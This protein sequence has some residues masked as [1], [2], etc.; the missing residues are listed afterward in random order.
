MAI[1]DLLSETE[2]KILE[3]NARDVVRARKLLKKSSYTLD[4][5]K[6][7][8][9]IVKKMVNEALTSENVDFKKRI[10]VF[11]SKMRK[12]FDTK[13]VYT[14]VAPDFLILS[15]DISSALSEPEEDFPPLLDY[16]SGEESE[17]EQSADVEQAPEI[18]P[19]PDMS[20][21]GEAMIAESNRGRSSATTS[22]ASSQ[23][24]RATSVRTPSPIPMAS[25]R[26]ERSRTPRAQASSRRERTRS[27]RTPQTS[28]RRERSRSPREPRGEKSKKASKR[29]PSPV[30]VVEC[31]TLVVSDEDKPRI[32]HKSRAYTIKSEDPKSSS[33]IK[34]EEADDTRI[35]STSRSSIKSEEGG[36]ADTRVASRK[37]S[38]NKRDCPWTQLTFTL[39]K[40]IEGENTLKLLSIKAYFFSSRGTHDASGF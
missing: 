7:F 22:S 29:S 19:S 28:E 32:V 20:A 36:A 38:T 39:Q 9:V 31:V 26:R 13:G 5:N 21:F 8:S 2:V 6:E 34:C 35:A 14:N 3:N 37:Q 33:N 30:S 10:E 18:E 25:S 12:C 23:A 16:S 1:F 17:G 11:G 24:P 4:S 15:K 27:P 40:N